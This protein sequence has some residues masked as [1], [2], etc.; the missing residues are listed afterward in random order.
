MAGKFKMSRS[1]HK[2]V[3]Y[4]GHD[5]DPRARGQNLTFGELQ[6]GGPEPGR[7]WGSGR[8]GPPKQGLA[9][10]GAPCPG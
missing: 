4:E 10:G 2:G 6:A 5:L 1:L 8:E 7:R 3:A 9:C